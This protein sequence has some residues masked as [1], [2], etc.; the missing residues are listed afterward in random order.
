MWYY[1][2]GAI[3][4][5]HIVDVISIGEK[6]YK[7]CN[8]LYSVSHYTATYLLKNGNNNNNE[9][10]ENDEEWIELKVFKDSETQTY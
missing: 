7:V 6:V 9:K 4:I 2:A 1:L 8:G 5:S 10:D 3:L